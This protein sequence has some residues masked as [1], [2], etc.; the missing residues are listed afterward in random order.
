MH[1]AG[2]FTN[3][4]WILRPYQSRAHHALV[5]LDR[6]GS[7]RESD[8]AAAIEQ[9]IEG[10]L[11][12]MGWHKDRIAAIVLDPELEIWVW[13]GSPHVQQVLNI[14]D[15]QMAQVHEKFPANSVG[16][17]WPPKEAMLYALRLARRPHSARIF[18]ELA[19][20]VSLRSE[21]RAFM[22]LRDTVQRW[23]PQSNT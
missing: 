13:S 7:G 12:E 5:I 23:F 3:A 4:Q 19:E 2:T 22:R 6:H 8:T 11:I 14:T 17:P 21:E 10:R 18:E 20:R 1:D 15:E 16:K 9:D